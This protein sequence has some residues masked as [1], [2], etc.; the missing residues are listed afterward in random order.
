M[1]PKSPYLCSQSSLISLKK[2]YCR[3]LISPMQATVAKDWME[4]ATRILALLLLVC[5][6]PDL[7]EK[8]HHAGTICDVARAI[9][10]N[11]QEAITDPWSLQW[12]LSWPQMKY[13]LSNRNI[14]QSV[15]S[16]PTAARE[17][18]MH[19]VFCWME[20]PQTK[21]GFLNGQE[22]RTPLLLSND[23]RRCVGADNWWAYTSAL[24]ARPSMS[25]CILAMRTDARKCREAST[26]QN[27]ENMSHVVKAWS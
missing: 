10:L 12:K 26:C 27:A 17:K 3:S 19:F 13:T 15:S 14:L 24:H 25:S 2:R 21:L 18:E 4:C 8:P 5:H 22:I 9:L 7:A 1:Q 6:I 11:S 16:Q 20:W 23:S